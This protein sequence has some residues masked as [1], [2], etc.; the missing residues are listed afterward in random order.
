MSEQGFTQAAYDV[1]PHAR[2]PNSAA[3]GAVSPTNS[4]T[5]KTTAE[6]ESAG[7]TGISHNTGTVPCWCPTGAT[8]VADVWASTPPARAG[9]PLQMHK[10]CTQD[11]AS[12][13]CYK[14]AVRTQKALYHNKKAVEKTMPQQQHPRPRPRVQKNPATNTDLS[15][16][17]THTQR[18]SSTAQAARRTVDG[19]S[20]Q[21]TTQTHST[22]TRQPQ[23]HTHKLRRQN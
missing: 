22:R 8:T 20:S 2:C 7:S 4:P 11:C 6:L 21:N 10:G 9:S 5:S 23:R 17:T 3:A 14:H 1:A 18:P 13:R 19:V 16:C 12:D 15:H